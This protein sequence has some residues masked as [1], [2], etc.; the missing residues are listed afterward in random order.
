MLASEATA[1]SADSWSHSL[2]AT[3]LGLRQL[4]LSGWQSQECAAVENELQAWQAA[5]LPKGG[6]GWERGW[7]WGHTQGGVVRPSY[8]HLLSLSLS[9]C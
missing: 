7:G 9:F 5:G 1:G 6:G 2:G 3:V 8:S 4:G